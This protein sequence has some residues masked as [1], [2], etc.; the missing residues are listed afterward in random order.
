VVSPAGSGELSRQKM[1]E[2]TGN[3]D[4]GIVPIPAHVAQQIR[5][6]LVT[7]SPRPRQQYTSSQATLTLP[8]SAVK[9]QH[10]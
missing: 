7:R 10:Q 1:N 2:Y 8:S 3:Y 5:S 6:L 9:T 4:P